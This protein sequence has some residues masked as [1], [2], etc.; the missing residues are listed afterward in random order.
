MMGNSKLNDPLPTKGSNIDD[1]PPLCSGPTPPPPLILF[2]WS[3]TS[4]AFTQ[5]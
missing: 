1:P 4:G 2:Y 3:L 5:L